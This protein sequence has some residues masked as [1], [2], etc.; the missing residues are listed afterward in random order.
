[1]IDL[2]EHDFGA[3]TQRGRIDVPMPFD[4]RRFL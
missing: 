1:M 2:L 4:T 3:I